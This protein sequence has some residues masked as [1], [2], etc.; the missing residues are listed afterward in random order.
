MPER[1]A[2][3]RRLD[4]SLLPK[5]TPLFRDYISAFQKV[6]QYYPT[7]PRRLGEWLDPPRVLA[8][9]EFSRQR[10]AEILEAQNKKLGCGP[11]AL[12]NIDLL[13]R[14]DTLVVI[15]GQQV[16]LFTGPLFTIY[17]ALT[18]VQLARQLSQRF[19]FHFLPLFWMASDDHDYAEVNSVALLDRSNQLVT[20][21]HRG[22][23]TS[24]LH[25]GTLRLGPEIESLLTKLDQALP[26]SE[27]K[28]GAMELLRAAYRPRATFS[29]AFGRAMLSL[30]AKEG[31]ILVDP[32]DPGLKRLA[33]PIFQKELESA[34]RSGELVAV[35][36]EQLVKRG[37]HAQIKPAPQAVNLFLLVNGARAAVM[38]RG[39]GFGLK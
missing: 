30:F 37:Y 14:P 31:L 36:G 6:T 8:D 27:F 3:R 35:R 25:V 19:P 10:L 7:D 32:A 11:Q 38:R 26:E 24:G 16:G 22:D 13:R 20:L 29:E 15:T 18:V 34:P 28:A 5:T 1:F 2:V 4:F 21:R 23:H 17:K 33:V 9:R 39:D 12:A